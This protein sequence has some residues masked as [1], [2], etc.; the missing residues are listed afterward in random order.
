MLFRS[1]ASGLWTQA[2]DF[3]GGITKYT[4]DA[5]GRNTNITRPNGTARTHKYDKAG[6]VTAILDYNAAGEIIANYSFDYDAG[7]KIVEETGLSENFTAANG[8]IIM[9]YGKGNRLLTYNGEAVQY[10]ADANMT[11]EIGR[12]HV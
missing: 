6:Q 8:D 12:A 4:Y 1:D 9:T 10:D 7:G 2:I 3:D 5:N 11:Y